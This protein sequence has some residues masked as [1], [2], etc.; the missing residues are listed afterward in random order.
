MQFE[1]LIRW[2]DEGFGVGLA[3]DF[4]LFD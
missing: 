4:N 2:K 1:C 3:I